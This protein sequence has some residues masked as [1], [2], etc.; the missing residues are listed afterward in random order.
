MNAAIYSGKLG[1]DFDL[2]AK[3]ISKHF[4]EQGISVPEMFDNPPQLT[5][6]VGGSGNLDKDQI[7]QLFASRYGGVVKQGNQ[8][9][10]N[11]LLGVFSQDEF[12]ALKSGNDAQLKA[13]CEKFAKSFLGNCGLAEGTYTITYNKYDAAGNS[14]AAGSYTDFGAK[15]QNININLDQVRAI[16]N[17]A[18]I[19]MILAHE[20]THMVDSAENKGKGMFTDQGFGLLNNTIG[21]THGLENV[22]RKT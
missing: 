7:K 19:V 22:E 14:N 3:N 10:A 13:F 4:I 20:L 18:E 16:K 12:E 15:G 21:G 2:S 6:P 9:Q 5:A 1:S 17:P 11:Y 8:Q